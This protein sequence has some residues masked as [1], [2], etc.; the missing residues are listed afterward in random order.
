MSIGRRWIYI[1]EKSIEIWPWF[2]VNST[3]DELQVVYMWVMDLKIEIG[4]EN[5][6]SKSIVGSLGHIKYDFWSNQPTWWIIIYMD[7][8]IPTGFYVKYTECQCTAWGVKGINP[9][10]TLLWNAKKLGQKS[11]ELANQKS[12]GLCIRRSSSPTD[13]ELGFLTLPN[14]IW[15]FF[16]LGPRD[17]S[18]NRG[19]SSF[20][21]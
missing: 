7:R 14:V 3:I 4:V 6:V 5:D 1:F 11:D 12:V 17:E 16:G 8:Y 9:A 21:F 10:L 19:V 18:V 20:L 2:I 13:F 15:R